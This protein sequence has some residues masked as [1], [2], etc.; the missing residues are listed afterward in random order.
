MPF[1]HI[2]DEPL[3]ASVL[4]SD[5][6]VLD[7]PGSPYATKSVTGTT[8]ATFTTAAV[9]AAGQAL[10]RVNDTNVTLTLGGSSATALL[11]AT[12]LTLGWTGTLSVTRG[13]TG[14][15][16][17]TSNG[18]CY[19]DGTKITTSSSAIMSF[20]AGDIDLL[21]IHPSVSGTAYEILVT[22]S[23]CQYLMGYN[24]ASTFQG[25]CG[26]AATE[27]YWT[28]ST[29]GLGLSV[30]AS[31]LWFG[32]TSNDDLS[33]Y[34]NNTERLR[35]TTT[36]IYVPDVAYLSAASPT[37]NAVGGA[38]LIQSSVRLISAYSGAASA[39]SSYFLGSGNDGGLLQ[40]FG[41]G[42][43]IASPTAL[44]TN[45]RIG[46]LFG[47]GYAETGYSNAVAAIEYYAGATF[48]DTSTPTYMTFG[49][50]ASGATTRTER[51]KFTSAGIFGVVTGVSVGTS[52]Y[53]T[54]PPS[55]GMIV[56]G[57]SGF[58]VSSVNSATQVQIAPGTNYHLYMAGTYAPVLAGFGAYDAVS[59]LPTFAPS[60]SST[61]FSAYFRGIVCQPT[62]ISP[63]TKTMTGVITCFYAGAQLA[64]NAGTI[65]NVYGYIYDGGSA[66]TGTVTNAYGGYFQSPNH[67]TKRVAVWAQD[68]V[69]G[70]GYLAT[71]PPS[72][73]AIIEGSVGIGTSATPRAKL[74]VV[75]DIWTDWSDRFIGTVYQTGTA[76]KIGIGTTTGVRALDL[77]AMSSDTSQIRFWTGAT[78][79]VNMYMDHAGNVVLGQ[80]TTLSTSATNGFTYVRVCD[81]APTGA[82]TTF[83]GHVAMVYDA[84]NNKIYFYN[85]SWRSA[86]LI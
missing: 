69:V 73:G 27:N 61:D 49:T 78:P 32:S 44:T 43:T 42:G 10:T 31:A 81:G 14:V 25:I 71:T 28:L 36:G 13:G 40:L 9:V 16:T 86:V 84:T 35:L 67:G 19:Y 21:L 70:A 20:V 58:G 75:G 79:T 18:I 2:S 57:L 6:F 41:A 48:T 24:T 1:V 82:P 80:Q 60:S 34:R 85:G 15:G 62:C 12:S 63:S 47:R 74:E 72:N 46:G 68:L 39:N 56:Q 77:I 38:S 23:S 8:L 45:G 22:S 7:R 50:T 29:K 33:F 65:S 66:A 51:G 4:T 37:I 83:V 3:A 59:C 54:T 17:Q 64:S 76:Y 52:Y 5:L 26:T 55:N 11:A 53:S 30:S